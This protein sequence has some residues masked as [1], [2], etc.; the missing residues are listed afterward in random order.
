M[1]GVSSMVC[2]VHYSCDPGSLGSEDAMAAME[3]LRDSGAAGSMV[4]ATAMVLH[5]P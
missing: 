5:G 2:V 3:D 1:A 4:F